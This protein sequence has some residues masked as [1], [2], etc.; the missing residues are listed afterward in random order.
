MEAG[1]GQRRCLRERHP[2][3]RQTQQSKDH[4]ATAAATLETAP[5]PDSAGGDQVLLQAL[6]ESSAV[7][8]ALPPW[9]SPRDL[10]QGITIRGFRNRPTTGEGKLRRCLARHRANQQ[11]V[12]PLLQ[13]YSDLQKPQ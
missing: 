6:P 13:K 1:F 7:Q 9:S 3:G 2:D 4:R 12:K 11:A 5:A 8:S 10:P